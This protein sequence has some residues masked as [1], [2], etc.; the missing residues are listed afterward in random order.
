LLFAGRPLFGWPFY[1]FSKFIWQYGNVTYV[2]RM[3]VDFK[4]KEVWL[5]TL[6]IERLQKLAD[7]K[8]WSLKQL[9]EHTLF[10]ESIKAIKK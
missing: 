2:W 8:G 3:K 1:L 7:K 10:R 6:T 5:N 9:M 4:R